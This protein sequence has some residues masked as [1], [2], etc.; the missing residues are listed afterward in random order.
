M[1][2]RSFES[3]VLSIIR[4][5]QET[6]RVVQTKRTNELNYYGLAEPDTS[7]AEGAGVTSR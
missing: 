6:K 5:T 4:G 7:H 1:G 3:R 2:K